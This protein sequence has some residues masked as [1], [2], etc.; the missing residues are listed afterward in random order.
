[1][2]NLVVSGFLIVTFLFGGFVNVA[3]GQ[4]AHKTSQVTGEIGYVEVYTDNVGSEKCGNLPKEDL[5]TVNF[6]HPKATSRLNEKNN[7]YVDTKLMV[8]RTYMCMKTSLSDFASNDHYGWV[9]MPPNSRVGVTSTG[10]AFFLGAPGGY[11]VC[12]NRIMAIFTK[13][14]VETS[15]E[16]VTEESE[17]Y[18]M[19]GTIA[20][21]ETKKKV[22]VKEEK[23]GWSTTKKVVVGGL[24]VG[25]GLAVWKFWPRGCKK[26]IPSITKTP[27]AAGAPDRP[28]VITSYMGNG[29]GGG[30]IFDQSSG[31]SS[32]SSTVN[33]QSIQSNQ[34]SA[35][36]VK[37]CGKVGGK[38]IC[39]N[40]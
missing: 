2:K 29:F 37:K 30:N 18:H 33:Y 4:K 10:Q 23:H 39:A 38:L 20:T 17:S 31:S 7:R 8:G 5:D 1:M 21:T 6:Y 13:A 26:C 27:P 28:R 11:I 40:Q 14:E 19:G 25:G 16:E 9:A 34:Q 3:F 12:H 24:I 36:A 35:T 22:V 32:Q 15:K